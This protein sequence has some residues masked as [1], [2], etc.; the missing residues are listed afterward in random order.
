MSAPSYL[1]EQYG[2]AR[3]DEMIVFLDQNLVSCF[4]ADSN[5]FSKPVIDTPTQKESTG[6]TASEE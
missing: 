5:V 2:K 1:T 6:G 3:F 4:H